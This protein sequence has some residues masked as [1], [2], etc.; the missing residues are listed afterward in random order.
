MERAIDEVAI[1]ARKH[2]PEEA[3][4]KKKFKD[5]SLSQKDQLFRVDNMFVVDAENLT[6]TVILEADKFT[7]T[8]HHLNSSLQQMLSIC[9]CN[10][11]IS[12]F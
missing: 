1:K 12:M 6:V 11:L 2:K 10:R 9:Q 5:K 8:C 3:P 4:I 7:W